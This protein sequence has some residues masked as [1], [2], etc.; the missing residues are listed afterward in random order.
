MD[1]LDPDV[2]NVG[3]VYACNGP[4]VAA[5]LERGIAVVSDKPVAANDADY[6]RIA[7]LCRRSD[8]PPLITEFDLRSR[9]AFRAARV[10][11]E[12]GLIGRPVLATAQKSYRLGT[13]PGFYKD[14]ALYGGTL[15]WIAS[16]GIDLVHYVTGE[17]FTH[18][19]GAAGNVSRPDYGSMADHVVVCYEL[20]GGGSAAVHADFLRPAAAPTHGD[21]RLRLAG[22]EGV[23][24]VRQSRCTLITADRGPADITDL[25]T[26]ADL[27][28]DLVAALDGDA[29]VYGTEPSLYLAR[30]L[31]ISR[32]A[33]DDRARRPLLP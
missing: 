8:A 19:S 15:M 21:D 29:S 9:P 16:H 22:S 13:R 2:V 17:A 5:A 6:R 30:V 7:E 10:A 32:Q 26:G 24:E 20:D 12:R 27:A 14:R 23:V 3:A 1:K 25:D 31:L 18:V 11:V 4:I 33:V 28:R